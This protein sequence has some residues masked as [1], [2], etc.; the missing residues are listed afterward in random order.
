MQA[1]FTVPA[2]WVASSREKRFLGEDHQGQGQGLLSSVHP[3]W[4]GG[5]GGLLSGAAQ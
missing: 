2:L 4:V 3:G 1:W 5:G